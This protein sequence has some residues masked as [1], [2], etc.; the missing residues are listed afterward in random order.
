MRLL[1]G[2]PKPV[3]FLLAGGG[4]AAINWLVRFPL[5]WAMPF[6]VA[7]LI[8]AI[9]G[10]VVG[11]TLYRGFVFPG[12]GRPVLLE[13]RDFFGVNVVSSGVVALLAVA[14]LYLAVQLGADIQ[15]A[16]GVAHAAAIGLGAV[17]NYFG[18]S[19]ITFGTRNP[20]AQV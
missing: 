6:F 12:S 8:A 4:A 13:A 16:E 15:M 10:M 11:F 5:S 9:I 18:H 3:R 19:L 2:L 17:L 20:A 14:F 7:V 1:I